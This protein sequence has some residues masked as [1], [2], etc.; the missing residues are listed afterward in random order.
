MDINKNKIVL[1]GINS[2]QRKNNEISLI[3]PRN[4]QNNNTNKI[5]LVININNQK[6]G[7]NNRLCNSNDNLK[8]KKYNNKRILNEITLNC[9][10]RENSLLKK[11][12][13]IVKSN[14]VISDK[15]EQINKKTIKEI[16]RMNKEK[17]ISYK[18]MNDLINEYKIKEIKYLNKI[19]ELEKESQKKES[20]LNKEIISYKLELENKDKI[21]KEL[22]SKLEELNE[23]ILNLKKIINE[24]NRI[25]LFLTN[26]N[27]SKK[28]KRMNSLN[29]ILNAK[30]MV[31]SK[32]CGNIIN[33]IFEFKNNITENNSI[34][35]I[36]KYHS[37]TGL[38]EILLNEEDYPKNENENNKIKIIRKQSYYRKRIPKNIKQLNNQ[39]ITH[40]LKKYNS[41]KNINEHNSNTSLNNSL[42]NLE[43]NINLSSNR[44]KNEI[45]L[46][47]D[48]NIKEIFI[49]KR[50]KNINELKNYSFIL[51]DLE[52][53]KNQIKT[54]KEIIKNKISNKK[55]KPENM[56]IQYSTKNKLVEINK[57]FMN[58]NNNNNPSFIS[59]YSFQ[60]I[61]PSFPK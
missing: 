6:R 25:L 39:S 22:N 27:N 28:F 53:H 51:T 7:F 20:D 61:F 8:N 57:K 42:K 34:N 50:I 60:N 18:N 55:L 17:E 12:I 58:N 41:N 49:N 37:K 31:S 2:N 44:K 35:R 29:N 45:K 16:K 54:S 14:L 36:R 13:E 5:G 11:E 47:N 19:K 26:K 1:K 46:E 23:R 10:E 24:K 52:K 43:K 30:T 9:L 56:K 33:K 48:S 15:K 59:N 3:S 38:K 21:I 40:I 32:S 4:N